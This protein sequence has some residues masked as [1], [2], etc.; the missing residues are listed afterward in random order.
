M[1][2]TGRVSHDRGRWSQHKGS[3]FASGFTEQGSHNLIWQLHGSAWVRLWAIPCAETH[4]PSPCAV[5]KLI[6]D[7]VFWKVRR[8]LNFRHGF[9]EG[10]MHF[11]PYMHHAEALAQSGFQLP[12]A[13]RDHPFN[14]S[15]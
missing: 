3:I 5:P 10:D 11:V 9:T 2:S 1:A 6:V 7:A 13:H 4:F 8:G 14:V 12:N 15:T